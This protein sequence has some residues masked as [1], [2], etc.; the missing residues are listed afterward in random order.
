MRVRTED[1]RQAILRAA[2]D[3]FRE[4]GFERATMSLITERV[5]GSKATLYGYFASKEELF[6]AAMIEATTRKE[7]EKALE[8]LDPAEPDFTLAL[9]RFGQAYVRLV[10]SRDSL[11]MSRTVIAEATNQKLGEAFYAQ[12]PKRILDGITV[13]MA[14]LSEGGAIQASDPRLAAIHF[15]ALLDAGTLL[16]LL[17]GAKPELRPKEAAQAAVDAFLRAY[18]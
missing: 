13:Y 9:E 12:G 8:L 17:M 7:G 5:G 3:V 16:P 18:A 6:V 1:R 15:H 14:H 4:V 2:L 10:S 11:A